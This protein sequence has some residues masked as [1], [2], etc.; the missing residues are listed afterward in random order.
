MAQHVAP[1][2]LQEGHHVHGSE[3]GRLEADIQSDV[4]A[5]WR[6]RKGG[7][8]RVER[9]LQVLHDLCPINCTGPDVNGPTKGTGFVSLLIR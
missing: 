5:L 7:Q 8:G 9:E 4:L 1:Q 2:Q 3:V 6:H